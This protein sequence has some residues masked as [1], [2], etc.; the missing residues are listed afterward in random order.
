VLRCI[1]LRHAVIPTDWEYWRM[2]R[3]PVRRLAPGEMLAAPRRGTCFADTMSSIKRSLPS[4]CP[5]QGGRGRARV[6]SNSR[7]QW[8]IIHSTT[9][10]LACV[11]LALDV[12]LLVPCS[13]SRITFGTAVEYP[14]RHRHAIKRSFRLA[15]PTKCHGSYPLQMSGE[16]ALP[17]ENTVW[18]TQKR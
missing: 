3:R 12:A 15:F 16:H 2:Q 4:L 11:P 8:R 13:L 9:D 10:R 1:E 17:R 18:P 5:F 14:R 6:E 7:A